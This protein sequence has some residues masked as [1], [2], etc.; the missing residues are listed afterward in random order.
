MITHLRPESRPLHP[1][2]ARLRLRG[3]CSRL[4]L[5]PRGRPTHKPV[6]PLGWLGSAMAGLAARS[7]GL[8]LS[9]K[10]KAA[11]RFLADGHRSDMAVRHKPPEA[12]SG[13]AKRQSR[14]ILPH[15]PIIQTIAAARHHR[16]GTRVCSAP[17]GRH[18]SMAHPVARSACLARKAAAP[19]PP[20]RAG[21]TGRQQSTEN[22]HLWHR[23]PSRLA[24]SLLRQLVL[25]APACRGTSG[26]DGQVSRCFF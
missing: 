23:S 24:S 18:A 3:W 22:A 4:F 5:L 10:A 13:L 17:V 14:T 2:D 15:L 16:P 9:L 11:D 20:P 8:L 25:S 26:I 12:L 1:Q 21:R 6:V 19:G 7:A